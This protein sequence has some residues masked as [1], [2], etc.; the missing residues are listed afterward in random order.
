MAPVPSA[1]GRSDDADLANYTKLNFV[2]ADFDSRAPAILPLRLLCSSI[3]AI[4]ILNDRPAE[5]LK[6]MLPNVTS[7]RYAPGEYEG[8]DADTAA[9]IG[10]RGSWRDNRGSAW[11][12]QVTK[13]HY[14]EQLHRLASS[15]GASFEI[16]LRHE[17]AKELYGTSSFDRPVYRL[18]APMTI[19]GTSSQVEPFLPALLPCE[20]SMLSRRQVTRLGE[21]RSVN[22][23][24]A[25]TVRLAPP[26]GASVWPDD[27]TAY[28]RLIRKLEPLSAYVNLVALNPQ[29]I[30][31]SPSTQILV[32]KG[33]GAGR[34]TQQI[35]HQWA[36]QSEQMGTTGGLEV[37]VY[38]DA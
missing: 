3:C 15:L 29:D 8:L 38:T 4:S 32:K 16:D 14:A 21:P 13:Q 6:A 26:E 22:P 11:Q 31:I 36:E 25:M 20:R 19:T 33:E 27:P 10:G 1:T 18:A 23:G 2:G 28:G 34:T 5:D 37:A 24:W 35:Q 30:S 17:G 9:W 12:D 7:V